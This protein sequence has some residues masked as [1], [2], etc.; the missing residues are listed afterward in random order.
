LRKQLFSGI[1]GLM[2]EFIIHTDGGCSGNPG[3]G[4]WAYV[5]RYGDRLREDSGYEVETTN[6]RMELKAVI[7]ALS[8]LAN[9]HRS[10]MGDS[11]IAKTNDNAASA[12]PAPRARPSWSKSPIKIFTDS[13]YVRNGVLKW[14]SAWKAR[15]WK[16]TDKKPVK[17]QDLWLC[18]DGLV[19][20]LK[21]DFF[22]VEGHAGNPDN[23]RCDSM[24]QESVKKGREAAIER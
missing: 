1:V 24:V 4:A 7:E 16:T 22:W 17:N 23:E 18:L 15:G 5:M 8:Y 10:A 19:S 11:S 9:L 6:N 13:Q 20:E 3:P 12:L 21:P 14:L 2:K